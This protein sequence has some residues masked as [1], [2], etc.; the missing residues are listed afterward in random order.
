LWLTSTNNSTDRIQSAASLGQLI[1][2]TK[3]EK[4]LCTVKST[5]AHHLVGNPLPGTPNE[6]THPSHTWKH[7]EKHLW[8]T[9]ANVTF[10]YNDVAR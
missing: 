1:N 9:S 4:L 7:V 8:K 6:E 3:L 10:R 5:A 2:D